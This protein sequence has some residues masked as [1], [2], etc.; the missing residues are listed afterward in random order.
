MASQ[1]KHVD[2]SEKP[3]KQEV[4]SEGKDEE[5]PDLDKDWA[6]MVALGERKLIKLCKFWREIRIM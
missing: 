3:A 4:D 1:A 5:D 6:W 2:K